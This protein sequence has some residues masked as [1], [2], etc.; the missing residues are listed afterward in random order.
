MPVF[1]FQILDDGEHHDTG[2]LPSAAVQ[3]QDIFILG[4][5]G[6]Q[7]FAVGK[8]IPDLPDRAFSD[9]DQ[10]FLVAFS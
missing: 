8:V 6:R 10:P 5:D 1:C 3:E 2:K 7:L 4:S 9:G